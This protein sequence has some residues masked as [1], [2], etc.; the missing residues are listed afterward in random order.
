MRKACKQ[1]RILVEGGSCPICQNSDFAT[2][3]NGRIN[4]LDAEKSGVAKKLSITKDGEYAI[5]TR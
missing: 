3:W 1:C 5:K 2:S 4:V